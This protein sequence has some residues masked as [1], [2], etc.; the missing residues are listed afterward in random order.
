MPSWQLLETFKA[1]ARWAH[2]PVVLISAR[3]EQDVPP[4]M[5]I[6]AFLQKPFDAEVLLRLARNATD[7]ETSP[8]QRHMS[9]VGHDRG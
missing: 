3:P 2:A 5:V 6:D 7:V 1:N 9:T 4:H 8:R